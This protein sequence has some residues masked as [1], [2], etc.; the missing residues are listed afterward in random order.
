MNPV[1]AVLLIFGL[2]VTVRGLYAIFVQ[3]IEEEGERLEGRAAT[4]LGLIYLALGLTV[5]S[6]A[7]FGWR[8]VTTLVAWV[9]SLE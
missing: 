1:K 2:A 3:D 7:V 8:W 6:H 4:R 5:A 9:S